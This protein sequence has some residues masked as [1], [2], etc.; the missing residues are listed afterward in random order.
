MR[1]RKATELWEK[2]WRGNHEMREV[3]AW[4]KAGQ[5]T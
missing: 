1:A 3:I 5:G 4:P 2:V